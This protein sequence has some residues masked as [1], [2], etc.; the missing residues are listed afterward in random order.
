LL[1]T[2]VASPQVANEDS[3]ES[4]KGAWEVALSMLSDLVSDS[5]DAALYQGEDIDSQDDDDDNDNE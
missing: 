3:A 1:T 2:L 5:G 4:H